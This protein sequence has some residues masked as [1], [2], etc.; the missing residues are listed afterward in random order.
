[1]VAF[2][3]A[4]EESMSVEALVAMMLTRGVVHSL[5]SG[6][7]AQNRVI[8]SRT[9]CLCNSS[10]SMRSQQ[11]ANTMGTLPKGS[12]ECLYCLCV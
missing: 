7:Y 8:G 10:V 9:V 1:M 11:L 3:D 4:Y 12:V 5:M 2:F 6:K